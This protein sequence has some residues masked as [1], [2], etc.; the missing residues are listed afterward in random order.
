MLSF[1]VLSFTLVLLVSYLW[2]SAI[3][4]MHKNHPEYKGEDF[5]N[6]DSDESEKKLKYTPNEQ[7]RSSIL[8]EPK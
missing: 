1:I 5:L 3:D 7:L 2:A 8:E 6:F 4:K